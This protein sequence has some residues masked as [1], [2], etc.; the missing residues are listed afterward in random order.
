MCATHLQLDVA[1]SSCARLLD[2]ISFYFGAVFVDQ[3]KKDEATP[4]YADPLAEAV[5]DDMD[6]SDQVEFPEVH[7]FQKTM[8][9][10]AS[11][12]VACDESGW[13]CMQ[14]AEGRGI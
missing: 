9:T 8:R 12:R 3:P 4:L 5:F 13:P 6:K 7:R 14:E 11:C 10:P 1:A 2:A